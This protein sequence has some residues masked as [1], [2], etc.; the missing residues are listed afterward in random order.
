MSKLALTAMLMAAA[1]PAVAQQSRGSYFGT[2][3]DSTGAAVPAAKVILTSVATNTAV[4]TE[5]NN[6]GLYNFLSTF[7]GTHFL[8]PRTITAQIRYSF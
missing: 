5:T 4:T 1:I 7:S 6:D 3:T 8:T 2:V